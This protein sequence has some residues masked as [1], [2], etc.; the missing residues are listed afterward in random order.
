M[1]KTRNEKPMTDDTVTFINDVPMVRKLG[2]KIGRNAKCPC[3]SGNKYKKCCLF[4]KKG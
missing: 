2:P 3:G 4:T 1:N